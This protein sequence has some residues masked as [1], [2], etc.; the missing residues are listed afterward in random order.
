MHSSVLLSDYLSVCPVLFLSGILPSVCLIASLPI[1]LIACLSDCLAACLSL[2][3]DST[4]DTTYCSNLIYNVRPYI[5]RVFIARSCFSLDC[6][7]PNSGYSGRTCVS[8]I[9]RRPKE[10][11][12][13]QVQEATLVIYACCPM[14]CS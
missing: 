1:C 2:C 4:R 3:L 5:Y 13:E 11:H 6:P 10:C 12:P 8:A 9:E 14:L 7:E